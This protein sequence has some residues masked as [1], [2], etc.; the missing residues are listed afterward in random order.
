MGNGVDIG[1]SD[2]DR[3]EGDQQEGFGTFGSKKPGSGSTT[4]R[5]GQTLTGTAKPIPGFDE[6]DEGDDDIVDDLF[7]GGGAGGSSTKRPSLRPTT[8]RPSPTGRPTITTFKPSFKP[9]LPAE[10]EDDG[11]YKPGG[12]DDG[13]YKPTLDE[14]SIGGAGGSSTSSRPGMCSKPIIH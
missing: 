9:P 10:E 7:G 3:L 1:N 8:P 14:S 6:D 2:L 13:S 4:S 5:P 12:S 11:S